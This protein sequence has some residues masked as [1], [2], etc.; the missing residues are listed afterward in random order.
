MI[1]TG[2]GKIG[3]RVKCSEGEGVI[4]KIYNNDNARVKLDRIE[5]GKNIF[6]AL[7]LSFLTEIK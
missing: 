5:N 1:S 2:Q 4:D 6:A 7:D 3:M